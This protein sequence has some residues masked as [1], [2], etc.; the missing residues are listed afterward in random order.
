VPL[1]HDLFVSGRGWMNEGPND[2]IFCDLAQLS[3]MESDGKDFGYIKG[4]IDKAAQDGAWLVLAGHEIG[5]PGN[6]TTLS[7]TIEAICEYASDP[8]NGIWIAPV[9]TIADFLSDHPDRDNFKNRDV[10]MNPA[11]PI[12]SRIEDLLSRMTLAEKVGQLNMPVLNSSIWGKNIEE[13]QAKVKTHVTGDFREGVGPGGGFFTMANHILQEGTAQQVAFFNELQ[14]IAIENTRLKIPI[15]QVEEGTHGL[16]CSGG[17]IFPE[18]HALGSSWNVNMV[19]DVYTVAAREA[20]G[21]LVFMNYSPWSS[22]R[23]GIPGWAGM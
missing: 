7:S 4:L 16:M 20:S 13:K 14:K 18:G 17:T 21:L 6:Q 15:L 22:N 9:G 11:A 10:Y 8:A 5:E 19:N 23:T 12:D 3:G 2:P 1:I